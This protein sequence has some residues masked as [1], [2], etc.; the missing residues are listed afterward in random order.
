MTIQ[1]IP[2]GAM[3][4]VPHPEAGLRS[5]SGGCIIQWQEVAAFKDPRW[6][7]DQQNCICYTPKRQCES[8]SWKKVKKQSKTTSVQ[9]FIQQTRFSL[10]GVLYNNLS[11]VRHCS[12]GLPVPF[13][14]ASRTGSIS[15][16]S[17]SQC[18][19]PQYLFRHVSW[20]GVLRGLELGVRLQ[21]ALA[22]G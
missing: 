18:S 20:A 6:C 22:S 5:W 17:L 7:E 12:L 16:S 3:G 14:I 11:K 21:G 8:N 10:L 1:E 2:Q 19:S 4:D 13:L 9:Y 15:F